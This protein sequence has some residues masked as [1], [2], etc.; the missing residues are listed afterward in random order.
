VSLLF[1]FGL[2]AGSLPGESFFPSSS[3]NP[4]HSDEKGCPSAILLIFKEQKRVYYNIFLI[5]YQSSKKTPIKAYMKNSRHT[6]GV[7]G[8]Y[9]VADSLG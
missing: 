3:T 8:G 1:D 2:T 4:F 6:N 7:V 5:N 9:R